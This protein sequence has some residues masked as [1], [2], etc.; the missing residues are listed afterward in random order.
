MGGVIQ[1][2]DIA[3]QESHS[4]GWAKCLLCHYRWVAV[5]PVGTTGFEC[6]KCH[7]NH[8]HYENSLSRDEDHWTCDC[9]SQVF[10]VTPRGIYCVFCG[11]WQYPYK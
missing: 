1:L 10:S 6:P 3:G 11:K 7:Y 8:G 5:V 9:E 4:S 2:E